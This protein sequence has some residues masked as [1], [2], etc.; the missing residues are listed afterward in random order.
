M[1]GYLSD[2]LQNL[3]YGIPNGRGKYLEETDSSYAVCHEIFHSCLGHHRVAW[4]L[5]PYFA[6]LGLVGIHCARS[7]RLSI[8]FRSVL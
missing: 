1:T 8:D 7:Y 2:R 5:H 4:D 3:Y 6:D